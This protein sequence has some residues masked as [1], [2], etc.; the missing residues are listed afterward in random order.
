M[1]SQSHRHIT[2]HNTAF[3]FSENLVNFYD[4]TDMRDA[5]AMLQGRGF[6]PQHLSAI[7]QENGFWITQMKKIAVFHHNDSDFDVYI[8][9]CIANVSPQTT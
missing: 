9:K 7:L 5:Y 6:T 3:C 1:E 8:T 2:Y 4:E